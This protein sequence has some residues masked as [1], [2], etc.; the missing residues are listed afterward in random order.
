M[1]YRV[2]K[3]L[4]TGEVQFRVC[5][6]VRSEQIPNPVVRLGWRTFGR[7][8]QVVFVR[9]SLARMKRLVDAELLL[10][11]HDVGIDLVADRL[12]VRDEGA[13]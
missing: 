4:D 13:A 3:E 7:F 11:H 10:G 1:C 2:V 5:R 12:E 9:R 6:Y 8:M